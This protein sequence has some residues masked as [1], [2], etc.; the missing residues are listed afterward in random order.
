MPFELFELVFF[1]AK[2]GVKADELFYHTEQNVIQA[3]FT[4]TQFHL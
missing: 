1:F 2:K 4:R 3:E